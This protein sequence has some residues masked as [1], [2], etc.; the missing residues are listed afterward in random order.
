MNILVAEDD[1]ISRKLLTNILE[2]LGHE[3][4]AAEDGEEAWR[5][6]Q[7]VPT[8][9]VVSDWLMPKM[10]GIDLVKKIRSHPKSDY[11]YIVMLT[12]NVGQRENYFKAMDAGVDDFLTKPLDRIQLTIRLKVAE[13]I[14][15]ATSRI[16]S[17]ENVLTI[18]A[19]TK[20]INFPEEGWQTIEEFM[21]KH[22][23][24]TVSHGIEPNYYEQVIK[25][26]IEQLKVA[27]SMEG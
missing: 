18:C 11:T 25:P 14:L 2:E 9:L 8:R 15:R 27:R 7:T 20:K 24:I 26:Q 13:R 5:L 19:Y 17:L 4:T 6:Y 10:D 16:H 12:A 1:F 23:G 3:V 22:F 21:Q